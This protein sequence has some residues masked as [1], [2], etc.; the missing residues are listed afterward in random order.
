MT[1]GRTTVMQRLR[2]VALCQE[3]GPTDGE[4]MERFT[5]RRDADALEALI[6]R[7]GPMVLAACRRVLGNEADAEDAFQAAFLVFVRKAPSIRSRELVG[8][9]LY[10][11][12]FRTAMKA[13]G[14][15]ARRR[16]KE[17]RAATM[18]PTRTDS[19]DG[20]DEL[21][22]LLDRELN[23]LS[24]KYRT[25]IILC[26]LEGRPRKE[27]A[28]KLGVP[29]GT[30]SSRLATGKRILARRLAGH[31]SAP[32]GCILTA[33]LARGT[34]V[35]PPL[36]ASTAKAASLFAVGRAAAAV[37]STRAA[38]LAE[39]VL[40]SMLL[41]KI[42][43]ACLAVAALV[44]SV[45]A[46]YTCRAAAAPP[47]PPAVAPAA[48]AAAPSPEDKPVVKK[49]A[50]EWGEAVDGVQARLRLSKTAWDVGETPELVLDLRNKG[51]WTPNECRVPNFCEIEWD[52][53]WYRFGGPGDLDCPVALLEPGKEID[54][55]VK[56]S[57]KTPW[58]RGRPARLIGDAKGKDEPLEI[59]AGKHTLRVAFVFERGVLPRFDKG[60]I[61]DVERDH[62]IRPVSQPV[63]IEVGK[64][65]EW[66]EAV[67]GVQARLRPSKTAWDIGE[68]PEFV[69]DVRNR[70]EKAP[71][72]CRVPAFC[73]IEW[74][75]QSYVYGGK[76]DLD[77]KSTSLPPGK[78]IDEWVKL[79][80]DM[81]WVR[82][83]D[84][85]MRLQV[86]A[87]KHTMRAAVVFNAD[88]GPTWITA[89]SQPV[90]I[91][92]GKESAW[93]KEDGGIQARIR[94]PKAAWEAGQ[95]PMFTLDLRNQGKTTPNARRVPFGCQIEVDGTWYSYDLPSGPYPEVGDPLEPGKLVNG[96]ATASPDKNWGSLN[97]KKDYFPL[98]PGKHTIRV[99]YP[100][101]GDKPL[102][103]VSG[104]VEI[105]VGRESAWGEADGGVQARL[106]TPKAVWNVGEAPTFIL[107]LRTVGKAKAQALHVIESLEIE[108]DGAWN[109]NPTERDKDREVKLLLDT[110]ELELVEKTS[111][112][113]T[114]AADA[115]WVLKT[116]EGIADKPAR[117]PLPP[118]M[119]TIRISYA[120]SCGDK[121]FRP[122][123]GTVEIEVK[124]K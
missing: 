66:G 71:F 60:P 104:S 12:A 78:E 76:G 68:T 28:R 16:M 64:A 101:N 61:T 18:N 93:G 48:V 91:E 119:H 121:N 10:G 56:P 2:R 40:K 58:L 82:R 26:E 67:Q 27:A 23:R 70:G 114:V 32:A 96:W 81:T 20:W 74:D 42:T 124:V 107:D 36:L 87:G 100:L 9:W 30:L 83:G 14:A 92:V 37:A 89:V 117:F 54:E 112:W 52:G 80:L 75:G 22:P 57:L 120:V 84:P 33:A 106:R 95:A 105:E 90:E 99:A 46:A 53:Q 109:W 41:T 62:G 103:P 113:V 47:N 110:D 15:A 111:D 31:R 25:P 43:V 13:R 108:A 88:S 79:S 5:V 115:N 4:L 86:G 102:R 11:V 69:L 35:P 73:E 118:G 98:P 65:P 21:L 97:G 38:V 77:C 94:T 55:W 63:E 39:G 49:E 24:E 116:P 122:V 3:G 59:S 44:A 50:P 7:H 72:Q 85:D 6:R 19:D 17:R 123:S 8:A 1:A 51:K 34:C 45:A 29:E